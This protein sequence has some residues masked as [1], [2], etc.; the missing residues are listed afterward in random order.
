MSPVRRVA[1]EGERD[2]EEQVEDEVDARAAEH[3]ARLRR[4]AARSRT[5][6]ARAEPA[7]EPRTPASIHAQVTIAIASIDQPSVELAGAAHQRQEGD[8]A[9]GRAGDVAPA[10]AMKRSRTASTVAPPAAHS[11]STI[12]APRMGSADSVRATAEDR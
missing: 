5:T 8:E 7:R 2:D 12:A 11:C 9:G 1:G 4:A 10:T 6:P 3:A